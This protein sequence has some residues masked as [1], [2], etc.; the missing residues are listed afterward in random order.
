M[1]TPATSNR[2]PLTTILIGGLLTF[3]SSVASADFDREI[4]IP[5]PDGRISRWEVALDE[6]A[7][8]LALERTISIPRQSSLSD[9]RRKALELSSSYVN[10]PA[11][12]LYPSGSLHN[13]ANR[14]ILSS[15]IVVKLDSAIKPTALARSVGAVGIKPAVGLTN[16][17][18][19]QAKSRN[20]ALALADLLKSLPGV[21]YCAPQLSHLRQSKQIPDDEFCLNDWHLQNVGQTGGEAGLDINIANVYDQWR[22]S[23]CIIG[24]VDSGFETNHP[25]LFPNF[26]VALSTNLDS[27]P[28][29]RTKSYHGTLVA[30]VAGARGNNGI[31]VVGVAYEAGL[32]DI[33]LGDYAD[34]FQE[35]TAMSIFNNEIVVKNNSWG[36]PD[37]TFYDP[38]RLDGPGPLTIAALADGTTSSRNGLGQIY[39]FPSGNGRQYG[40]NANY[41]GYAN[42]PYVICVG[43]ISDLGDQSQYSE[44]GACLAISAPSGS[45][46]NTCDGGRARIATTDITG[47]WGI[48]TNGN[49]CDIQSLDYTTNF[50][51]TSA[52]VPIISGVAALLIESKP[53]L[54]WRDV[55]EILMRSARKVISNDTDWATN[56]AGLATNPK[57]GAGLVD[58]EAAINLATNWLPCRPL[59]SI[60]LTSTNISLIIP[61]NNP[62]G[63]NYSFIV[64]NSGFRV[65]TVAITTTIQHDRWGD[66]LIKLISPSGV[67][68]TFAEPHKTRNTDGIPGWSFTSVRNWGEDAQGEWLIQVSDLVEDVSGVIDSLGM[69]IYGSEPASLSL[70]QSNC[71]NVITLSVAPANWI[72]KNYDIQYSTNITDWITAYTVE[73]GSSGTV[74]CVESNLTDQLRFY[75]IKPAAVTLTGKVSRQG[76]E[77][78]R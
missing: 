47:P 72:Y 51:G 8:P 26:K 33:R 6:L 34:D 3:F 63:T 20:E 61:D 77:P 4:T 67:V 11:V 10:Q 32:S 69:S 23:S 55:K 65:E 49:S 19:L 22:G 17:Y 58:A 50:S 73:I 57:C 44:S 14:R 53:Q 68:S 24:I 30:G 78:R 27:T 9:L 60:S 45:G 52:S 62:I 2:A 18:I 36:A 64:S 35:A 56:A 7:D 5:T 74:S 76:A 16:A 42:S 71:C 37:A 21:L 39:V 31:G 15:S 75:R 54:N 46:P 13:R 66:L 25:D 28:F 48:N 59:T 12:I 29:D 41:D 70:V 38:P 1:E 40:D 43:S